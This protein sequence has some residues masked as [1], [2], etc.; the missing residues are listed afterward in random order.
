MVL[1][2][3]ARRRDGRVVID[4]HLHR[5]RVREERRHVQHVCCSGVSERMSI[6]GRAGRWRWRGGE[7]G[8]GGWSWRGGAAPSGECEGRVELGQVHAD[9]GQQVARDLGV[10]HGHG[11]EP[12]S[13]R[14]DAV[15]LM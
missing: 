12:L 11:L 4:L 14:L 7:K 3:G 5:K 10:A 8:E 1:E 15:H 2:G 6:H 13:V 9:H